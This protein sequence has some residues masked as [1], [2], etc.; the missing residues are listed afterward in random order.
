MTVAGPRAGIAP[1]VSRPGVV[2]G[3]RDV[4][5]RRT[6]GAFGDELFQPGDAVTGRVPRHSGHFLIEP[7]NL[8]P[9]RRQLRATGWPVTRR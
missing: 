9:Q 8:L 1:G 7:H 4:L 6:L 3:R 5:G 2:S